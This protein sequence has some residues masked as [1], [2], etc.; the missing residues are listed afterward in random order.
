MGGLGYEANAIEWNHMIENTDD[1]KKALGV[2]S[3]RE[4]SGEKVLALAHLLQ[5]VELSE[6]VQR[7]LMNLVPEIFTETAKIMDNSV[8]EALGS[9]D[10]SSSG[11]FDSAAQ[12]KSIYE[13][14]ILNSDTPT[15]VKLRAMEDLAR[16]DEQ[17]FEHDV[18]NKKFNLE[19]LRL[20][21][22]TVVKIVSGATVAALVLT[23]GGRK[24][25][26]ESARL[27]LP[28]R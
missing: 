20:K 12:S 7:A 19:A 5:N 11:Y 18:N 21:K 25:L 10:K 2:D 16:L 15:D 23:P 1:L 26:A 3:L 13:K 17:V 22:E 28:G 6:S 8:T 4:M 24:L 14:L 27:A 9:N